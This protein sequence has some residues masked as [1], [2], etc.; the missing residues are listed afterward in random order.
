MGGH[1]TLVSCDS[2]LLLPAKLLLI[3]CL[4]LLVPTAAPSCSRCPVLSASAFPSVFVF[5][6]SVKIWR[7]LPEATPN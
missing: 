1:W 6:P 3:S 4:G 5:A 7:R 2:P